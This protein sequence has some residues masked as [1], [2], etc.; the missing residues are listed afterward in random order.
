[1][2]VWTEEASGLISFAFA[3]S[4]LALAPTFAFL[5]G[6]A[7]EGA[8]Q[9]IALFLIILPEH[10]RNGR[11]IPLLLYLHQVRSGPHIH[12]A[13]HDRVRNEPDPDLWEQ[14]GILRLQLV[15]AASRW[16]LQ[17]LRA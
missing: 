3:L 4:V 16:S 8:P 14:L 12:P 2:A 9:P 7:L 17:V 15:K 1:M 10:P 5:Q 11:G 13:V 6:M